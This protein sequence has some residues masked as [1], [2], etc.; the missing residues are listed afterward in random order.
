MNTQILG[1]SGRGSKL[2]L[3]GCKE[4]IG[5]PFLIHTAMARKHGSF[6]KKWCCAY[7]P[8]LCYARTTFDWSSARRML[9]SLASLVK[10]L[11]L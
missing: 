2:E 10:P 9:A 1:I 5:V 6:M 3:G 4:Y 8:V 7:V 11:P